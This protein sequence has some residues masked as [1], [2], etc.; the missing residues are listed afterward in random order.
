[1][2]KLC[3]NKKLSFVEKNTVCYTLTIVISFSVCVSFCSGFLCMFA[4]IRKKGERLR[5][6]TITAAFYDQKV[7]GKS[8]LVI[9]RCQQLHH[10]PKTFLNCTAKNF[11]FL[12]SQKD[13]VRPHF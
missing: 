13:L 10:R 5:E 7:V 11:P 6:R 3:L 8:R 4:I 2:Q 9:E 1:M 12:Y